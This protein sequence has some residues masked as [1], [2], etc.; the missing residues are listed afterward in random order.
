MPPRR[1]RPVFS[2]LF[3]PSSLLSHVRARGPPGAAV[4]PAI[5]APKPKPFCDISLTLSASPVRAPPSM[6]VPPPLPVARPPQRHLALTPPVSPTRLY[7]HLFLFGDELEPIG[8]PRYYLMLVPPPLVLFD[9]NDSYGGYMVAFAGRK[10]AARSPPAFV[11]NNTFIVTSF[12]LVLEFR[13]YK[14]CTG[15]EMVVLPARAT[16]TLSALTNNCAIGTN[17]CKKRGGICGLQSWCTT[18]IFRYR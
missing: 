14:T 3:S 6:L 11:A 13:G 9:V 8:Y 5:E 4:L 12:T 7:C 15:K 18:Y 17:N 2:S 1:R 10:Y 16:R